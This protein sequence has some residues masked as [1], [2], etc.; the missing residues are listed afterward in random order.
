MAKFT[1]VQ[2]ECRFHDENTREEDLTHPEDIAHFRR[3]DAEDDEAERQV[4]LD[5]MSIVEVNIP[6]KFRRPS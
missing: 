2:G 1:D 6:A 5:R 3:H 4:Q